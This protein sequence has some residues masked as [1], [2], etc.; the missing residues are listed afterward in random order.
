MD[1]L[2][3]APSD[4]RPGP[5][6]A[7]GHVGV[8][9]RVAARRAEHTPAASRATAS[10][11]GRDAE[12]APAEPVVSVTIGRVEIRAHVPPADVQPKRAAAS[13][14]R[15]TPLEEYVEQRVKGAR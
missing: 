13:P 9:A 3:D 7:S 12:R 2:L 6:D 5:D 8:A 14:T 4:G 10:R 1:R 15:L 11:R